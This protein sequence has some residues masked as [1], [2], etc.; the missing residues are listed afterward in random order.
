MIDGTTALRPSVAAAG[1]HTEGMRFNPI[2]PVLTALDEGRLLG[3]PVVW[4]I[5]IFA[6][7]WLLGT[8]YLLYQDVVVWPHIPGAG[9]P[10]GLLQSALVAMTMVCA[11]LVFWHRART[12]REGVHAPFVV[13]PTMSNIAKLVGETLAVLHIGLGSSG[14]IWAWATD[15]PPLFLAGNAVFGIFDWIILT[16]DI[17]PSMGRIARGAWYL[18]ASWGIGY[19]LLMV[20]YFVAEAWVVVVFIASHVRRLVTD[21]GAQRGGVPAPVLPASQVEVRREGAE[22]PVAAPRSF[23]TQC[24]S[25]LSRPG[26]PCERC[27]SGK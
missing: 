8:S 16:P 10:A 5:R 7:A 26:A 3:Q 14:A 25:V 15:A 6:V 13:I 2:R 24:G 20:G 9:M 1:I 23:C 11:A 17:G 19:A 21:V 22:G 27:T 4:A 18:F 12:I